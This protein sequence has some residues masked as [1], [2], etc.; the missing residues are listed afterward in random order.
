[1]P[2]FGAER[3]CKE[4]KGQWGV[5]VEGTSLLSFSHSVVSDSLQSHGLQQTRLLCP[6]FSSKV[7]SDSCPLSWWCYITISSSA[8]P[9]SFCLQSF[10]TSVSFPMNWLISS[11]GQ[12]IGV[13]ASASVLPM[14]IQGWFPLGLT[15]LISLKSKGL[16]R[17]FSSE[18]FLELTLYFRFYRKSEQR[19]L[20]P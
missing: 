6:P 5:E 10:P 13:S 16:L 12:S 9:F 7:Y 11:G 1:M 20:F 2:L 8:S 4:G 18:F 15:G 17:V 14:N 19:V 3:L